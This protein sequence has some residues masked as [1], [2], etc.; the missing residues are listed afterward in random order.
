M[1]NKIFIKAAESMEFEDGYQPFIRM[2]FLTALT[3]ALTLEGACAKSKYV[4]DLQY[5]DHLQ[6]ASR[7]WH[8]LHS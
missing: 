3:V 6:S 2:S 7:S 4:Y 8:R 1:W 5:F